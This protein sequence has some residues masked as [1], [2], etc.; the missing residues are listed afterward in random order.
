MKQTSVISHLASLT[1]DWSE[2]RSM[3]PKPAADRLAGMLKSLDGNE[4]TVFAWRGMCALLIEEREL[5]KEIIDPEV[6]QPYASLDRFLKVSYPNS[7]SYVRD[8]LRAVKELKD[9]PFEELLC[10]RR[11]NI[12]QLK[13]VSSSVRVLPE[14]IAAAKVMPEKAFVEKMNVDFNQALETKS[15][16]VMAPKGDV[17]EF[18]AAIDMAIVC[19]GCQSRVEAMKAIG[20]FYAIEHYVEYEHKKEADKCVNG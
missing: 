3:E 6:G 15:P 14:V 1:P 7:W 12:E 13:K 5:Y 9:M 4:K 11:S 2:I 17:N 16:V 8:A 19:E 18:E 20:V 10:I